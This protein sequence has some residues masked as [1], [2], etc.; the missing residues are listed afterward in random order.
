MWLISDAYVNSGGY[1]S[2]KEIYG[3]G[4]RIEEATGTSFSIAAV[5]DRD[6][7]PQEEVD[8]MLASLRKHLN[9]AW[10]FEQ[11]EIENY[12]LVPTVLDRLILTLVRRERDVKFPEPPDE[13]GSAQIL[14]ELTNDDDYR[15]EIQAEYVKHRCLYFRNPAV[16]PSVPMREATRWFEHQWK[17]LE[18]RLTV[19][20]GKLLLARFREL[21]QERYSISFSDNRIVE[22]FHRD[23]IPLELETL[24]S[25]LEAMCL[26]A[27]Q[28]V[29]GSGEGKPI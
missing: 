19:V 11:K 18:G 3:L 26:R 17:T 1:G 13:I 20:P 6:Y 5:Y 29:T 10:I 4:R 24:L 23:E 25:E 7:R 2:W 12:L 16:D 22:E 27:P 28:P 14:T 21:I 8:E 15:H 9:S